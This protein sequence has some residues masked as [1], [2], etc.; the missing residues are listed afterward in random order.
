MDEILFQD[1][2][3]PA[4][5]LVWLK[6]SLESVIMAPLNSQ[7][8][9]KPD[10]WWQDPKGN[11]RG[12]NRKQL[13]EALGDLD[14]VEEQIN[15]ELHSCD[16]LTWV[17]EGVGVPL[18][19]GY[20]TFDWH[21]GTFC[22]RLK[23]R[24]SHYCQGYMFKRNG[25]GARF[26]GLKDGMR[27]AGIIVIETNTMLSTA[28]AIVAAFKG[29]M[30]EERTTLKRY[31]MPHVPPFDMDPHVDNLARLKGTGV[32]IEKAKTLIYHCETLAGVINAPKL[33]L[34]RILGVPT[35]ARFLKVIGRE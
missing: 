18:P 12:W 21:E 19:Q 34:E 29:S 23:T 31:I 17:I 28:T 6:Q 11:R 8:P 35:T 9:I 10:W 13:G 22:H 5:M 24:Q 3:E 20:Q 25:L 26:E 7:D 4:Q 15:R 27:K 33:K 1:V 30:K 2:H 14:A 32:G 16:E